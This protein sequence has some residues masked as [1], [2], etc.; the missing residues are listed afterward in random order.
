MDERDWT[1]FRGSPEYQPEHWVVGWDGDAVAGVVF[2][3]LDPLENQR[4]DRLWG[5][6][7]A[8]A[9]SRDYRRR[10]LAKALLS[11]SLVI[12]RDL[13]MEH[14]ALGVDTQNPADA[15]ALYE[16]QGYTV[17]KE[18]YDMVRPMGD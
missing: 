13:G 4:H 17:H 11:R 1:G 2:C 3:W 10:G 15:M 8:V 12:L 7:D 5:Y 6:N 18:F 16:S 14:A 9:V